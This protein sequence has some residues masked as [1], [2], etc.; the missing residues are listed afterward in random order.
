MR[1]V[2][3][4]IA[5]MALLAVTG[6]VTGLASAQ[7]VALKPYKTVTVLAPAPLADPAFDALRK[8][9]GEAAQKKDRTALSQLVVAQGFFWQRDGR[10]RADKRKSGVD[11]LATALSL[12]TKGGAGWDIL[13]SYTDDP[14]ASPSQAFKGALCAPGEPAYNAAAFA[15]L[16]KSTQSDV[17]EWGYTLSPATE[18]HDK[19]Q[20]SAPVV[21]KLAPM[22]VRIAPE[23]ASGSAAYQRIIT[24][25]GKA[26]FVTIDAVAPLGNDQLCYVKDGGAW[27]I[28]GYI[29][30][31]ESQ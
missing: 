27:K 24:P 5:A 30:G 26:G 28:G 18:V 21:E 15:E 20:A 16:L 25:S 29:G 23:N 6:L 17:S 8:Q 4:A 3:P 1:I 7:P 19:P 14:T 11:N 13:F 2:I 9:A 31:G 10:D 12:N 22:F